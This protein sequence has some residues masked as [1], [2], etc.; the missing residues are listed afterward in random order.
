MLDSL[1]AHKGFFAFLMAVLFFASLSTILF[2]LALTRVFSI[3]L[4]YDY[5]F[6]AIS[7]A[8]FGLG[9]G[10]LLVHMQ[11]DAGE[12]RGR[13][14]SFL[15]VPKM[16]PS[17]LTKK[18]IQ[19][20][21]AY[22]VSV[23]AFIFVVT[24]IPPDPSFI[25]LFYLA[26]SVPFFFA[27]SIMAL[28]FFA[29]PSK[30]TKLYFADL[31]GASSAALLLDPLML[32]LG[33]ESVML[34]TALLVA[35][36]A[37]IGALMVA[38][39]EKGA[40]VLAR[41]AKAASSAIFAGVV[42]MLVLGSP[43]MAA[44][45]YS[46]GTLG[47]DDFLKVDPGPNKGLYWQLRHPELFDH[48]STQW[49]SFSRIDVTKQKV[50]DQQTSDGS[51]IRSTRELANI[52]IDAD[53][54]TPIYE[55]GGSVDELEWM[56][57]YMG[58]LPYELTDTDETLV[59]GSGGG[60]D[61]LMALAGGSDR[62]TAVEINPLIV[63]AVRGF[64]DRAGNVY[65]HPQ[66]EL[67]IDDGRHFVGSSSERYDVITIKLVDSWAA[68][69]AGGYA[70][71]ENYL[72]TVEAFQQYYRHLDD[73]GMLAMIRWNFEL[74]RLMPVVAESVAR[75]T[76]KSMEEVSE[77]IVVVEDRPGLYFGR[78]DDAQT[79]YPV[80]VMV[81]S[82]PF[83]DDEL[84]IVEE[85]AQAGR[86]EVT[87]LG[88]GQ[89]IHPYG[90]LFSTA[91]RDDYD[92][93]VA[94]QMGI[95]PKVTT[96][97]SPFYFAREL[98]PR[99]MILLLGTVLAISAAL[100]AML[101]RH[102][103]KTREWGNP[104]QKNTAFVL[105]AVCIGLGF[106]ILEITFIQKFLLLLG[107]PIMALTV[108]LFSI[109]LSSGIG[110]YFSG[111]LFKTRPHHAVFVSVP[112]LAGMIL[113]YLFFLQGIIDSSIAMDLPARAA[114]TFALLSPAGFLMGFQF[115][116]LIRIASF[117]NGAR[118]NTTL[119]WG[120]NVVASIIGTV[121][122]ALLGMV[123]GFN[124]NLLVG[125]AMY[126]GAGTSALAAFLAYRKYADQALSVEE[127]E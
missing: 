90:M 86:A 42:A 123:I 2:E 40:P 113:F 72:Y 95:N 71:S 12:R 28:I 14:W 82:A 70:L 45:T 101:V 116:S 68:E 15:S 29:M 24:Q 126:A 43:A 114:L 93:Y 52:I 104:Q 125:L 20:S 32:G 117:G 60:Q 38:G 10:S 8:F 105:F 7:V 31:V 74:P 107:T 56:R 109:L 62:V 17:A 11:K 67:H 58:Y 19:H 33:A 21:V 92:Q 98:I 121:L 66:V 46:P 13:L 83:T 48:A 119:L 78:Q 97:D 75:E 85:R 79:Y 124:G 53:A 59:I 111:R 26:S 6:M 94:S 51:P 65:D 57:Q 103:R 30:I 100:S 3:V 89:I 120:I 1:A 91:E 5:A 118:N 63:S 84:A 64:G 127:R 27:G 16:T 115:P 112:V 4:W 22:A 81:K 96:D 44:V 99:Q 108:I 25:Y 35:G 37:I 77:H 9:I 69:L 18:L 122:A 61:I 47:V 55:W 41:R 34:F 106:M 76:G 88:G 102:A 23:P 49:N 39:K 73:G 110:A 87:M 36:S 54:G 50:F 80:L